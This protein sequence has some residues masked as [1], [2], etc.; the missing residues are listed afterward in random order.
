MTEGESPTERSVALAT[1]G[2]PTHAESGRVE[3]AIAVV[4]CAA[5]A[6]A[7]F[8]PRAPLPAAVAAAVALFFVPVVG[9]YFAL[10]VGPVVRGLRAAVRQSAAVRAL[11][12]PVVLWL[13]VVAYATAAGVAVAPR[14]AAFALYLAAPAVLLGARPAAPGRPPVRELAAVALLWFPIELRV[15]PVV[16]V[17]PPAGFDL[18]RFVG[19]VDGLYLF[20]V[21][22]PL[23]GVGYTLALRPRQL[24]VAV[25]VFLAYAVMALPLGLATGFLAWHPRLT[26]SAVV[27]RPLLIFVGTGVPEE[28]LF[29]GLVQNLLTRWWGPKRALAVASVVFGLAHLPDPRYVLLAAIAGVA[30]GLVYQ[31]TG[32]ITAA[33]VTHALVD[34]VWVILL[35]R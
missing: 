10:S 2:A 17:P 4:A 11:A 29:R 12:G 9:A 18:S 5:A 34:A 27:I 26:V 31:R 21:A 15:L 22:C 25:I 8:A 19:L 28:F 7:L 30:Y 1:A 33:A 32:R 16:P 13:A 24:G 20:L 14:A 35:R 23:P 6:I 3:A